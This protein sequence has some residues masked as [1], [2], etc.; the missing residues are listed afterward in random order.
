MY[1]EIVHSG[2]DTGDIVGWLVLK[3]LPQ[4]VGNYSDWLM[5]NKDTAKKLFG[6][7]D[8]MEPNANCGEKPI[9]V[10]DDMSFMKS[11]ENSDEP[12]VSKSGVSS[13]DMGSVGDGNEVLVQKATNMS[14]KSYCKKNIEIIVKGIK[15]I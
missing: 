5:S 9:N 8:S 3:N 11:G 13:S 7:E 4:W 10:H 1:F 15:I 14:T 12:S 2:G 6:E